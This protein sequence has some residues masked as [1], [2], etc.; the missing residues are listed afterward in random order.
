ML[1]IYLLFSFLVSTL[2]AQLTFSS[3]K[4]VPIGL[5]YSE[6]I[7]S[8]KQQFVSVPNLF[9]SAFPGLKRV[10]YKNTPFSNYGPLDYTFQ[11]VKD[12]LVSLKMEK[13]FIIYQRKEFY[14]LLQKIDLD[15]RSDKDF[16]ILEDFGKWNINDPIK[17]IE[18]EFK[19]SSS[20]NEFQPGETI[21]DKPVKLSSWDTYFAI[22]NGGNYTGHVLVIQ[23]LL[24]NTDRSIEYS[25]NRSSDYSGGYCKILIEVFSEKLQDLRLMEISLRTES[26]YISTPYVKNEDRINLKQRNGIYYIPVEV[27]SSLKIDF[28]IDPGAADVM[29][30]T[31]VFEALVKAGT[32]TPEDLLGNQNYQLADGST[33]NYKIINLKSVKIGNHEIKNVRA[34]VSKNSLAPLLLGQSALNRFRSYKIDNLS[35][36]LIIED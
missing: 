30:S 6:F 25:N 27:N 16:M 2:N 26:S 17:L 12:T 23:I 36:N 10:V 3:I 24:G 19:R 33:D 18:T 20:K 28:A 14:E 22:Y 5:H 7:R 11:Y 21:K 31:D 15:L 34:F 32:I 13:D 9:N 35:N 8:I 29:I 1:I 4:R